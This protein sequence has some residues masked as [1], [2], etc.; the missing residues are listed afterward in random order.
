MGMVKRKMEAH[1]FIGAYG[2]RYDRIGLSLYLG[3]WTMKPEEEA[4][5]LM[6]EVYKRG[7]NVYMMINKTKKKLKKVDNFPSEVIIE[8]CKEYLRYKNFDKIKSDYAWF[9]RVLIAKSDQWNANRQIAEHQKYKQQPAMAQS[10]KDIL[11]GLVG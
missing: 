5:N 10:V 3:W 1:S 8:V 11:K 4:K 9:I 2:G 7:C 6:A